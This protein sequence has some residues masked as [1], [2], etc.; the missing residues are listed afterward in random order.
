MCYRSI[1][2]IMK[3]QLDRWSMNHLLIHRGSRVE[4]IMYIQEI[5]IH[6][7]IHRGSRV[8]KIL[9]IQEI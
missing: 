8:E 1:M 6:I 7:V 2:M 3:S 9:Y 4:K 5:S